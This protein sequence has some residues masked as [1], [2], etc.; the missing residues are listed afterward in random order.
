[1]LRT[2]DVRANVLIALVHR[3][4][5]FTAQEPN[6]SEL[7]ATTPMPSSAFKSINEPLWP[8]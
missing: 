7:V 1:M 6:G 5:S 3:G 2:H 4:H 8:K